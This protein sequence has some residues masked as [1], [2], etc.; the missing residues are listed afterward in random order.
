[1]FLTQEKTLVKI[2]ILASFMAIA[3]AL[4]LITLL[5]T[6]IAFAHEGHAH[7]SI[8]GHV[9]K[10]DGSH[11]VVRTRE[12][13]TVPIALTDYTKYRGQGGEKSQSDIKVGDRVVVKAMGKSEDLSAD[14]VRFS[15]LGRKAT[16]AGGR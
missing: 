7:K 1:V 10:L 6:S 11:I 5:S 3:L 4:A 16:G 9:T 14:Q 13:K 12:G 15:H 2:R 8:M